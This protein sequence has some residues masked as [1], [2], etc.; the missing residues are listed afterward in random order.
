MPTTSLSRVTRALLD[1]DAIARAATAVVNSTICIE[2]HKDEQTF[3]WLLA[4]VVTASHP[5]PA[6]VAHNG[7]PH[8]DAVKAGEPALQVP[9]PLSASHPLPAALTL[10]LSPVTLSTSHPLNLSTCSTLCK[11][12]KW[13][14]QAATVVVRNLKKRIRK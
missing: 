14:V 10:W 7:A 13:G 3:P 1:A 12:V 11:R 2:T 6:A 5:A 4:T 9:W 8:L